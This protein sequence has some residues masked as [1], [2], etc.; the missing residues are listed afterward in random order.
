MKTAMK[1]FKTA[2]GDIFL[3]RLPSDKRQQLFA[4]DSAD[5]LILKHLHQE[6]TLLKKK[7]ILIINDNFGSLAC[8][9]S[10]LNNID[11]T[12][13]GDSLV[14][15]LATKNNLALNKIEDNIHYHKE[16][17]L[18]TKKFDLVLIKVPKVMAL[19]EWQLQQ[20]RRVTSKDSVIISAG[21]VK[22][23][24]KRSQ[25]MLETVIGHTERSLAEKKARLFFSTCE[26]KPPQTSAYPIKNNIEELAITLSNHA[27]VFSK[28]Q[29]DIGARFFIQHFDQLPKA[30]TIIDLGCG[31]GVLGIIAKKL[32][33]ESQIHF[34]DESYMAITSAKDNYQDNIS[35][36]INDYSHFYLSHC[37]T[38]YPNK[39]IDLIL[40]NPPFH[41]Q[42]SLAEKTAVT[43]FKQSHQLLRS[44]GELWIVANAHLNYLSYLK[45]LFNNTKIVAS[46][47][48]F[49]II[50]ARKK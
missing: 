1:P 48:K 33:P 9:L 29:L 11:I 5:E 39:D 16:L 34:V 28:E 17:Y 50:C 30:K 40:C 36:D 46:N 21:M 12:S 15:H 27:N 49:I 19:F 37:L 6:N 25:E 20:L 13:W 35:S 32:Q 23:L 31:N 26:D 4:W 3:D 41:Q 47:K 44:N 14:S 24:A 43:M 22:H 38:Q 7:H 2:F 10:K 18:D 8:T 42:Y 45:K